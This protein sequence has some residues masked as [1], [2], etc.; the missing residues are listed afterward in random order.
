MTHSLLTELRTLGTPT[1]YGERQPSPYRGRRRSR[2]INLSKKPS[3]FAI[4]L[5]ESSLLLAVCRWSSARSAVFH[6]PGR[7]KSFDQIQNVSIRDFGCHRLHDH[8]V[9]NVV[10]EPR[11]VRVQHNLV[12]LAVEFQDP[13]DCL[14]AVPSTNKSERGVVKPRLKDRRHNFSQR[15]L[16]HTIRTTGIP[17]GRS[18]FDPGPFG[19]C[20]RRNGRGRNTP[21]FKLRTTRPRPTGL[22]SKKCRKSSPPSGKPQR[23]NREAARVRRIGPLISRHRDRRTNGQDLSPRCL[24]AGNG[25]HSQIAIPQEPSPPSHA[26]S[27]GVGRGRAGDLQ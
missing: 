10:K 21:V 19:I 1:V 8:A 13:L 15:P 20:T 4:S 17:S 14:M 16:A 22:A 12:S 3:L 24:P 2:G 9:R 7:E 6:H 23:P 5:E 25:V 26:A 27:G 18:L 11:D